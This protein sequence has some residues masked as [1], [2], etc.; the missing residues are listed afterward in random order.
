MCFG[1]GDIGHVLCDL[2]GLS[3][4]GLR[5]LVLVLYFFDYIPPLNSGHKFLSSKQNK[6]R[7]LIVAAASTSGA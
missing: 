2:L 1:L 4:I 6:C 5:R 7:P 3:D